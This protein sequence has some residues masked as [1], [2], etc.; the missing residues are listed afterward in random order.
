MKN[1]KIPV[2]RNIKRLREAKG[3]SRQEVAARIGDYDKSLQRWETTDRNPRIETLLRLAG[4][5]NVSL[6]ELVLG[7]VTGRS[8]TQKRPNEHGLELSKSEV[9]LLSE[10]CTDKIMQLEQS[11]KYKD[12]SSHLDD[13]D[14]TLEE[15]RPLDDIYGKLVAYRNREK[16]TR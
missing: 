6:D 12:V 7:S 11:L 10:L 14:K 16:G 8:A 5:F 9:N 13:M 3:M 4:V 1:D 2:G 15:I